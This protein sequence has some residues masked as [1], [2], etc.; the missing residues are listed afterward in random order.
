MYCVFWLS[1][2]GVIGRYGQPSQLGASW[3]AVSIYAIAAISVMGAGAQFGWTV[4]V[5]ALTQGALALGFAGLILVVK[6]IGSHTAHVNSSQEAASL[7]LADMRRALDELM[8]R[9]SDARLEAIATD[10]RFASPVSAPEGN[11]IASQFVSQAALVGTQLAVRAETDGVDRLA[12]L[13]K[14]YKNC[15]SV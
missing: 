12:D 10:L 2:L 3:V 9:H 5:Q 1:G 4:T 6:S 11:R 13:A 8:S 15:Y 14:A 7:G